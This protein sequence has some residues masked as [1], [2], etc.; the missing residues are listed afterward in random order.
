MGAVQ[1]TFLTRGATCEVYHA[2]TT[3]ES[4]FDELCAMIDALPKPAGILVAYDDRAL[5]VV[6]ACEAIGAAV[7]RDVS[8]LS[9]NDDA[10]LCDNIVPTLSSIRADQE[11]A[12]PMLPGFSP[13]PRCQSR[14]SPTPPVF[15]A[16]TTS[17][18][19]S[20]ATTA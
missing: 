17:C 18:I 4:D 5:A 2:R 12:S 13:R 14:K 10:I 19:A 9:V 7:P 6:A 1:N 16:P 3:E 11:S 20:G 15:Q 8:I